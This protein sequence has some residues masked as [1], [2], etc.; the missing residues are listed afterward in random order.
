MRTCRLIALM[1]LCAAA[2]ARGAV[3]DLEDGFRD[4]PM[5]AR[6]W[7]Y[8]WWLN[9]NVDERTITRDL[10]AMKQYGFGG[11]LL[12]D[13][14]GYHD[15]VNHVP[16]PEPKMEFM[17]PDWRRLVRHTLAEADRLGLQ[18]SIN[19]SS[20]A[21]ALKGPWE[22]GDDAPKQLLWTAAGA[23]GPGRFTTDG[24][25][26]EDRRFRD[27]AVLAV[28]HEDPAA[29]GPSVSADAWQEMAPATERAVAVAE[30]V[31][32][33][34]RMDAQGALTWDVPAGRWT[35]LRFGCVTMKGHEFDVDILDPKAV[36]GHF[37]RMG[38]ALLDDAG[39]LAGRTLTHFYS[40]SWEGAAPTWTPALER[41]FENY[42]SYPLRPWLPVLAGFA[43]RS[44]A[45]SERF[46]HDYYKTLADCFA[47]NF[48]GTLRELSNRAGLQ[49]HA[50]SGGPWNRKLAAFEHAD[51]FVF[52]AQNDMPQGE[53]WLPQRA[54]HR[55]VAMTAHTHGRPLAAA[56]AFT[57]M[58]Q[59]W[60]PYPALLKPRADAAFCDGINQLIWHTF[61][62]SPPELGLPGSEYFAG[63]H[64]NPNVTW[65]SMA[66][67]FVDHLARCQFLLRQGRF[68]ADACVYTGDRPYLHWDQGVSNW[69]PRATLP[70]PR[71]HAF[72]VVSTDVLLTRLA[73]QDGH[74]VLPDGMT[75]RLLI[76]DLDEETMPLPALR[77]IL[78]L[79]QAGAT[80][81]VGR[82]QP[83]R[84]S[85][86]TDFPA[87]DEELRKRAEE[88]WSAAGASPVEAL[89]AKG[90]RPDFESPWNWTH[91]RDGDCDIYFVAGGGT[92]ECIFR[93]KGRQPELWDPVTGSRRDADNWR[94]TAD[95]RTAVSLSLPTNGSVFVVFRRPTTASRHDAKPAAIA[96]TI[97]LDGPWEV[98]FDPKLGGPENP[99]TFDRLED[100]TKRTEEGIR[101]YSGTATYRMRLALAPVHIAHRASRLLH[102]GEVNH[103]ARVRVNDRDCGIAWTAPWT[104]ELGDAL[105]PGQNEVEIEVANTW[106]NRLIGDA[107]LPAERRVTKTNVKLETGKR[108]LKPYQSFAPGD[109]LMPSGLPGPV[110]LEFSSPAAP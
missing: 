64:L 105:Q 13:A 7:A 85:G 33:T 57:H 36:T 46:L 39:P 86:R 99:V 66:R 37:S 82:R 11:L 58:L 43:V 34:D 75:Y 44:R 53:F 55:P 52:L 70:W 62:A 49:W 30:V 68:V 3:P 81:I 9:G 72:D 93:V 18:V 28:R 79:R 41:E 50:E 32:L 8:Y 67:P 42:R 61:T 69:S 54:L 22:V 12:F 91:R 15:D 45:E 16:A 24:R 27:V 2:F 63:T 110:R 109:P 14:R 106:V 102:L 80:V 1:A 20:C 25:R 51:Q 84:T 90:I 104:V 87:C 19:L 101:H 35:V 17:S 60:S 89:T 96:A 71:G 23:T 40:V 59:H 88:L 107:G 47:R 94:A 29:D 73:V 31:D 98:T 65:A 56:E 38:R 97:P 21:G 100:W 103:I 95:G 92:S 4:T 6:P 78:A 48:Y 10:A 26:P 108:A 76:V 74:L 5:N 77:K 83:L